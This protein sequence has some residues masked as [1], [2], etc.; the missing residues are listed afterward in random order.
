MNI[1]R[2]VLFQFVFL[3]IMLNIQLTAQPAGWEWAILPKYDKVENFHEG[4]AAV[5]LNGKYGFINKKGHLVIPLKFDWVLNFC[6]GYC[7][8][9]EG[10]FM[11]FIDKSGKEVIPATIQCKSDK[12]YDLYMN[13]QSGFFEE[14]CRIYSDK[15]WK[16]INPSGLTKINLPSNCTG[17]GN[18]NSGI[19]AVKIN[20]LWGFIDKE[21]KQIIQPKYKEL[22]SSFIED[23]ACVGT[24][25]RSEKYGGEIICYGYIDRNGRELIKPQYFDAEAFSDGLALVKKE[26][27]SEYGYINKAGTLFIPFQFTS[28]KSFSEGLAAV[29]TAKSNY[30]FID[31]SGKFVTEKI[32]FDPSPFNEGYATVADINTK[33]YGLIDKKGNYVIE[34]KFKDKLI[35]QEGL[36]AMSENKKWGF[37]RKS[38]GA[39]NPIGNNVIPDVNSTI[40]KVWALI[41]GISDYPGTND[42]LRYCDDDARSVY[43]FLKSSQGG[44][45]SDSQIKL[46]VDSEASYSNITS[47]AENLYS[48]AG[49]NDLLLFYFSGHG[50][51]GNFYVNGNS[52][53]RG[54]F[55][56]HSTLRNT[57][58]NSKSKKKICIA[59]ACH[60]GSWEKAKKELATSGKALSNEEMVR[61]YYSSL[62]E[63]GNG[64]ALFM[65][66]QENETSID[67]NELGQGL[68][69]Y[70]YIEGL[71]GSADRDKDKIITIEELY[72]Y[73]KE[74]VGER[75]MVRWK[76]SQTP[77]LKGTFDH[78][79]PIGVR[80]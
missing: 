66:C 29:K 6:N 78:D 56:S 27:D 3:G 59:D 50:T 73:V 69:T 34:P 25:C 10:N 32:Y 12:D 33:M 45:V 70:Y 23:L 74:K 13:L 22:N 42:D 1:K 76:N 71:K 20:N 39:E 79:M 47:W 4:L 63:A 37:I 61:L 49:E 18:F 31:K 40:P 57:L 21:G 77:K 43:N 5:Q 41:V 35:I 2:I 75:A 80:N 44:Q 54:E 64:L 36:C 24:T 8:F 38:S 60:S 58:N 16:Y 51:V 62:T 17:V 30:G 53:S 52:S 48:K 72:N 19:A 7:P 26:H 67:D 9:I 55:L 65:S 14:Y 11:G 68:F 15:K 46:L 28:A